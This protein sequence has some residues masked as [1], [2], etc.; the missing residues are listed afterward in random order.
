DPAAAT[1]LAHLDATTNLKRKLTEQGIY[2]AVDALASTS[3]ALDP[4]IVR[5]E[6]YEVATAVQRTIQRYSELQD[7]IAIIGMDELT[8]EDKQVVARSRRIQFILSQT[9]H[10]DEQ[11]TGQPGSYVSVK[12]TIRGFKELLDGKYDDIPEDAFRLVGPI[13]DVLEKA[14]KMNV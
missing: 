7:T 4:G 13:E 2:A 1:T 11:F 3:R 8:D 12:E 5:Q 10:V 14:E 9:F 6:H